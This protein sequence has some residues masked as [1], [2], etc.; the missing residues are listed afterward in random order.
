M[1]EIPVASDN[2]QTTSL[3]SDPTIANAGLT[4]LEDPTTTE[5]INGTSKIAIEEEI[6][7]PATSIDADASNAT[8]ASWDPTK[9]QE[10]LE[11]SYEIV[12][13]TNT[14]ST[15]APSEPMKESWADIPQDSPPA[16]T[17]AN[18]KA[19]SSDGFEEVKHHHGGRGP[20]GHHGGQR[21]GG[22]RGSRGG[23]GRGGFRGDYRGDSRG[24]GP[25]G[26]FRGRG[27][28]D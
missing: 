20:R 4:E 7:P 22:D 8:G 10:D 11:R 21:G 14:E 16:E 6:A 18:G 24:R 3:E 25:R 26:G 13:R 1:I 12:P 23:R 15:V 19:P 27:R 17:A 5:L 2:P 9:T 28:G